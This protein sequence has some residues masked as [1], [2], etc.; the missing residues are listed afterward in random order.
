MSSIFVL[1]ALGFILGTLTGFF[2]V[3]G[4]FLLTPALNVLGFS[5]TSAIG[6][7]FFTLMG[8]SVFGVIRHHRLGNVDL[9]LGVTLGI[10]SVVGVELG[11]RLVL[12][13]DRLNLAGTSVRLLYIVLLVGIAVSMLKV[14]AD[15]RAKR[16]SAQ[17]GDA[18]KAHGERSAVASRITRLGVPPRIALPRSEVDAISIWIILASG[19]LIGF[20]SGFMG[21]GGGVIGLPLLIYIIGVRTITAVGTSLVL[22]F[23]TSCCGTIVYALAES[24]RWGPA[25]VIL[26]GSLVG[27][28]LGVSASKYVTGVRIR[29]LFAVLLLIV[30]ISVFLKE[31]GVTPLDSYLLLGST[32]ALTLTILVPLLKKSGLLR[33]LH[34][35]KSGFRE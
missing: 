3:G 29:V 11:K 33:P 4:G 30:A 32:G 16:H 13:V 23:L 6:T 35:E 15:Q 34:V 21:I 1:L 8:N 12:H 14:Y 19:V 27:V 20:L 17:T 10:C 5:I 18:A 7:G 25:V 24:V 22:V 2:G 26:A 31:M 28:Q 9:R